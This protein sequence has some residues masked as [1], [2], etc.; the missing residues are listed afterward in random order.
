VIATMPPEVQRA[1][2]NVSDATGIPVRVMLSRRRTAPV[3]EARMTAYWLVKRHTRTHTG[4][5]W[6]LSE[7]SRVFRRDRGAINHG[8][9]V[10]EDRITIDKTLQT[11]TDKLKL[12][13]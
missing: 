4:R 11:I 1:V 6:T 2:I 7:L 8:I 10:I 12:S 5:E 13:L 9:H 3:A